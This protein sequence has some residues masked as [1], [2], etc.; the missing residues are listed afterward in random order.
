MNTKKSFAKLSIV[1]SV[2]FVFAVAAAL[3][4]QANADAQ[5]KKEFKGATLENNRLVPHA[6]LKLRKIS[7]TLVEIFKEETTTTGSGPTARRA[8]KQT[9]VNGINVKCVCG[10][11]TNSSNCSTTVTSGGA[12]CSTKNNSCSKCEMIAT[13]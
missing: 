4:W 1:L 13:E 5:G 11:T 6:G 10:G 7:D 8:T 9:R 12:T 2:A 3:L